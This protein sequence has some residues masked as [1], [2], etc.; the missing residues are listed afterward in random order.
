M[1]HDRLD[2]VVAEARTDSEC[3]RDRTGDECI[4]GDRRQIDEPGAAAEVVSELRCGSDREP[5]LA[6]AARSDERRQCVCTDARDEALAFAVA[7]DKARE[8]HRKIA[9]RLE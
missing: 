4:V 6:Y 5:R 3:R 9:R 7:P 8:L 2:E 1:L